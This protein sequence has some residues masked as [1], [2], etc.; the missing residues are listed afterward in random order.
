MLE[1]RRMPYIVLI[2][3]GVSAEDSFP[4][5]VVVAMSL[6]VTRQPVTRSVQQTKGLHTKIKQQV[7]NRVT[8]SNQ[9]SLGQWVGLPADKILNGVFRRS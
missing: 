5:V 7:P 4:A 8:G 6:P 3:L 1:Q 2:L 9:T